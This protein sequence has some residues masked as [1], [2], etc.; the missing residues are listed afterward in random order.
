MKLAIVNAKKYCVLSVNHM[1]RET[2]KAAH[3][4]KFA[5]LT[6]VFNDN[7]YNSYDNWPY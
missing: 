1:R 3:I 5:C 7:I 4:Y 2:Y 6:K